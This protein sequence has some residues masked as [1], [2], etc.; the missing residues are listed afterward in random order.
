[1]NQSLGTLLF[2]RARGVEYALLLHTRGCSNVAHL[3]LDMAGGELALWKGRDRTLRTSRLLLSDALDDA[4]SSPC[5]TVS[6]KNRG[7]AALFYLSRGAG[8]RSES[9]RRYFLRGITERT[10]KR[11]LKHYLNQRCDKREALRGVLDACSRSDLY[12]LFV[13]FY[14]SF[15]AG[16]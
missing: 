1:M 5:P 6:A 13:H 7:S 14:E 11:I 10:A 2:S 8:V 15:D 16:W 4:M 3:I 9:L 12:S